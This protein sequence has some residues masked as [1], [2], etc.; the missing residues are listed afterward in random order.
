MGAL[1]WRVFPP[2]NHVPTVEQPA[3][4]NIEERMNGFWGL[5]FICMIQVACRGLRCVRLEF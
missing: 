2:D 4:S 5:I 3:E 1:R